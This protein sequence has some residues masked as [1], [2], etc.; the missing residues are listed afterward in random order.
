MMRHQCLAKTNITILDSPWTVYFQASADYERSL[1]KSGRDSRAVTVTKLKTMHFNCSVLYPND[2]VA[3]H[4]LVHAY[5]EEAMLHDLEKSPG[6]M[7]EFFCVLFEQ[8]GLAILKQAASVT[9]TLRKCVKKL[10]RKQPQTVEEDDE[11]E[12]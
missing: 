3:V 6:Q 8:R 10:K 1:G 12:Q 9:R 2:N 11:D 7:E 4:E 5:A